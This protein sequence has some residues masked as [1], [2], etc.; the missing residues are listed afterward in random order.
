MKSGPAITVPLK[1]VS[2]TVEPQKGWARTRSF[3][4]D[5]TFQPHTNSIS[6][7]KKPMLSARLQVQVL[8]ENQMPT[9]KIVLNPPPKA[10]INAN[11]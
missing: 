5:S 3:T 4:S 7:K 10:K 8:N 9:Y 6:T 2:V 1:S 11:I